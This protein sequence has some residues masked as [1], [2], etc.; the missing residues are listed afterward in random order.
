[1]LGDGLGLCVVEMEVETGK[2]EEV[3]DEDA[4][5]VDDRL[6]AAAFKA[7]STSRPSSNVDREAFCVAMFHPGMTDKLKVTAFEVRGDGRRS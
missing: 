1:M 7:R 2:F 6:C 4:D 3:G 5:K